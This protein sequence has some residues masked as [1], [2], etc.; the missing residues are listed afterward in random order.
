[1]SEVNK[2]TDLAE[3]FILPSNKPKDVSTN[4]V[5]IHEFYKVYWLFWRWMLKQPVLIYQSFVSLG[6]P[7]KARY[8]GVKYV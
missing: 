2:P 5:I 7:R 4:D 3:P 1:M 6:L 8:E